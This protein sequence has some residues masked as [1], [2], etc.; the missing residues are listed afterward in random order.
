MWGVSTTVLL[1]LLVD[2]SSHGD[3][4]CVTVLRLAPVAVGSKVSVEF[5]E[6]ADFIR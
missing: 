1:L 4:L 5:D 6:V 2:L 3:H